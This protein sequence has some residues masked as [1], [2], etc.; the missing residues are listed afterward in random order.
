MT[1]VEIDVRTLPKPQKHPEIFRAFAG[2]D[3]D[4]SLLLVNNHDPRHLRDEFT[5][6]FPDGF[7]WTYVD[8]GP[9]EW[10]IRITKR[11]STSLP[12]VLV[13]TNTLAGE[14]ADVSGAIWKLQMAER[15]LD[16]NVVNLSP[17]QAIDR[18][19]GPDLDVLIHVLYGDG[20]LD[21]ERGAVA[22]VAGM[23]VWLPKR[24]QRAFAA[25]PAGLQYLSVHPRRT[26]LL[27]QVG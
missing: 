6:E 23:L 22:L 1:D 17:G 19:Q 24:S 16:A 9:K 3:V 26:G 14:M 5:T 21:T 27:L 10:R 18:H 7:D 13:D 15:D 11:A 8:R 12:R 2:L 4:A 20:K 25:G